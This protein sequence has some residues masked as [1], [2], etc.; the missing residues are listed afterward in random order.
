MR[1]SAGFPRGD[2]YPAQDLLGSGAGSG[3]EDVVV[4]TPN[5]PPLAVP[6][7]MTLEPASHREP[8]NNGIN[9]TAK[10]INGNG[11]LLRE[12][13]G[14]TLQNQVVAIANRLA[15]DL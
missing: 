12:L 6:W 14:I 10:L 7:T 3:A 4:G 2:A 8:G 15:V 1:I 9:G 13:A 11:A 5:K